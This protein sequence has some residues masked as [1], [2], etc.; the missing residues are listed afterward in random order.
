MTNFIPI[1]ILT[2]QALA[3]SMGSSRVPKLRIGIVGGGATGVELAAEIH[4]TICHLRKY[5]AN[6]FQEQLQIT[7]MEGGARVLGGGAPA[8][9]TFATKELE[10]RK[11]E[12]RTNA[13]IKSVT[14][15]GFLLQDGTLL[16]KD[17]KI[18]TAGI[19]AP[20][21]LG[22]LGLK[23]NK[24]NQILVDGELAAGEPS[25]FAMGDCAATPA[26][27]VAGKQKVNICTR[28]E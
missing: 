22:S 1:S 5:G 13:F 18:W 19:K 21:W 6:L 10:K 4:H 8:L 2:G 27:S 25:I 20:N 17:I 12:V 23:T 14:P 3:V 9:S 11:I 28:D 26:P 15:E 7:I 24:F 16:E